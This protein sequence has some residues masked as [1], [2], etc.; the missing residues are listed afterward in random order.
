MRVDMLD[1]KFFG[2]RRVP[3]SYQTATWSVTSTNQPLPAWTTQ[4]TYFCEIR[5]PTG[6]E[7]LNAGQ[8]KAELTHVLITRYPGFDFSPEGR[9][10]NGSYIYNILWVGNVDARNREVMIYAT[11]VITPSET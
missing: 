8:M 3:I 11:E 1:S 6:R 10:V 7:A 4:G 5:T 2:V 9:F